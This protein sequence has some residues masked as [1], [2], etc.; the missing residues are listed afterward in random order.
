LKN[1]SL[2]VVLFVI[3]LL[4]AALF[5]FT[6]SDNPPVPDGTDLY[7]SNQSVTATS[8]SASD[9]F[10]GKPSS[11]EEPKTSTVSGAAST[12]YEPVFPV[13]IGSEG[14]RQPVTLHYLVP[15][16]LRE[17]YATILDSL[18]KYENEINFSKPVNEDLFLRSIILVRDLNPDLFF[19]DWSLYN[20]KATPD[21]NV[22]QVSF[23]FFYDDVPSKAETFKNKVNEIVSRANSY[24]NLFERELFVHDYLVNNTVYLVDNADTGTAYGALINNKARCEGYARAFQLLMLRLGIPAYSVIGTA[25]NERHMWNAVELYGKNYFV[26]VTFDDNSSENTLTSFTESEIGHSCFNIPNEVLTKTHSI[27]GSGSRDKYGAYQ[28]L[29]LPECSSYEFNYYRIRGL[30]A[31]NSE[32]FKY[33]LEK[34]ASQKRVCVF[35][36]GEMP[37][38]EKLQS[39]FNDF[40]EKLYPSSG[41]SIYYTPS[42][43]PVFQRNVYEIR[44]TTTN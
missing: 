23:T 40:F 44:W 20:Y 19:I 37:T 39:D 27:S 7:G 35:F 11:G 33:L 28:N 15:E 29:I 16:E 38:S 41:Y 26:D 31:E 13:N 5:I 25:E 3:I 12:E 9:S 2:T 1:K 6:R 8:D 30:T 32:Q 18:E 34:N 14:I 10:F 42:T 17:T 22:T 24:P 4:S 21:D 36:K 43:S